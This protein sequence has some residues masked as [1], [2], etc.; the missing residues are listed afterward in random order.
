MNKLRCQLVDPLHKRIFPSLLT[1]ADG[2]I[3]S[4]EPISDEE[5]LP[6]VMPGFVDAHVHIESSMLM[7]VH[8][9]EAVL[10]HGTVA[11]VCDPHEIA[12]VLGVSGVEYMIDDAR[13]A[14]IHCCFAVPSCVPA[15]DCE[16][17]GAALGVDEVRLLLQRPDTYALAEMMNAVGVLAGD[18]AVLGKIEAAKA[19]GK[20]VDGHAPAMLGDNLRRYVEAGISTDHEC[21]SIEEG[22]QRMALGMKV[23][24]REGSAA[25]NFDI[26]APLLAESD[27]RLMFCTD[28]AHPDMLSDGHI[29]LLVRR[30]VA[31]GYPLWNVLRAA[32]VTPVLHYNL[33]CGLLREGDSAD[34]IVVDNLHDFNVLRVFVK[35]DELARAVGGRAATLPV[36][37][38]PNSFH[39]VPLSASDMEVPVRCGQR[40]RVISVDDGSL[41]SREELLEPRIVGQCAVADPDR[42]IAK[43]LVYN[44]YMPAKPQVGFI[45]GLGLKRGAFGASIAHDSHNIVVAAA[46]DASLLRAVNAI[47]AMR[48]GMVACDGEQE[49]E[50]LPLPIAGLMSPLP[51]GEVCKA[52]VRLGNLCR[53]L[54]SSLQAP[55]MTLSFMALPVIPD[56][57]MTDLGLFDVCRWQFVGVVEDV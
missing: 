19:V 22:R 50:Q 31:A 43:L 16:T 4:V 39:A 56:L 1:V 21:N 45:K 15:T 41:L 7:P 2:R 3:V 14:R 34:F 53:R 44:R 55:F 6:Y 40:I 11:A 42:D 33:P 37:D 10:P 24:I 20:P 54:G 28:D 38:Y 12:N 57:K 36:A 48:G 27:D 35:G 52:Y 13:K 29:D 32:C 5:G 17:A 18:A 26:L 9:A 49:M 23:L 30:A 8:F 51:C 46:D 47:V 25:R